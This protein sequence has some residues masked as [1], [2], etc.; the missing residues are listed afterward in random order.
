MQDA[1]EE[2]LLKN[3]SFWDRDPTNNGSMVPPK[4]MRDTL[5]P[6]LCSGH[7]KCEKGKCICDINFASADCSIDER[8]GPTITSIP[9]NGGTCDVRNRSDCHLTRIAGYDFIDSETLSCR[10]VKVTME[11]KIYYSTAILHISLEYCNKKSY[12]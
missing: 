5:C 9:G 11:L 7:G 1:C 4:E 3:T 10:A 2:V 12:A 8:K 6:S